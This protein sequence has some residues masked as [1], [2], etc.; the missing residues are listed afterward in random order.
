MRSSA[1]CAKNIGGDLSNWD[2]RCEL[3]FGN[4][5]TGD[6]RWRGALKRVAIYDRGLAPDEQLDDAFVRA[7]AGTVQ[8]KGNFLTKEGRADAIQTFVQRLT[9]LHVNG[10][11]A[12]VDPPPRLEAREKR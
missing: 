2:G 11:G 9:G 5:I 3:A 8:I 1:A 12:F 4:E 10:H 6:R 7:L